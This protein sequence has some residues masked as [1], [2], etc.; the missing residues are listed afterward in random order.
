[1][2]TDDVDE[3]TRGNFVTKRIRGISWG[4]LKEG[5][6]AHKDPVEV[7]ES[8]IRQAVRIPGVAIDRDSWLRK[9]LALYCPPDVVERAVSESPHA[10]G[11]SR[12]IVERLAA[13]AIRFETGKASGIS[14]AAGLPGGLA[15]AG[16]IPLD[17][18]QYYA[19]II[20]IEQKLAYVYGWESFL[21]PGDEVDDETMGILVL[22][23]GVAEGVGTAST[24]LTKFAA[25]TA[26]QGVTRTIQK[27]ALTK[28]AFY[29]M[30]KKIMRVLGVK[31][32][33]ESFAKTAGKVV[34][35]MGG[36]V[37]GGLTCATFTLSASRLRKHLRGLP[38]A[39]S[40]DGQEDSEEE[41]SDV[42]EGDLLDEGDPLG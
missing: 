5:T 36:V 16:T 17:M 19:H 13:K 12:E 15:L 4:P 21:Q 24:T 33:K 7:I 1:M 29:P 28:T 10:A 39:G 3:D 22:L 35:V 14:F 27:Q 26:R 6:L 23:L 20:R 30:I 9:E 40:P 41:L 42:L 31:V 18:A 34:P 8:L 32:T 2:S 38:Q 11:V 37:S 25:T